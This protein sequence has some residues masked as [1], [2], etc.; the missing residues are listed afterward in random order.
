MKRFAHKG[1]T[2]SKFDCQST[3]SYL[4]EDCLSSAISFLPLHDVLIFASTSNTAMISTLSDLRRRRENMK[5]N[6]TWKDCP[7]STH[8]RVS[9]IQ[10]FDYADAD[11]E[12]G[13]Y[14]LP[15]VLLRLKCLLK[16]IAIKHPLCEDLR[17]LV[18][19]LEGNDESAGTGL[20]LSHGHGGNITFEQTIS[21]FRRI[22]KA[23]KLHT[24]LLQRT[25]YNRDVGNRTS[26]FNLPLYR[27]VGDVLITYFLLGH[28]AA[29]N[30]EGVCER[31]WIKEMHVAQQ[32]NIRR[33]GD[34]NHVYRLLLCYHSTLLRTLPLLKEQM[35][36]IGIANEDML[37]IMM[38]GNAL[39]EDS[40]SLI[41][42][43]TPFRGISKY[44][45][46]QNLRTHTAGISLSCTVY[47]FGPLGPAFRGRD[48][49]TSRPMSSVRSGIDGIT[50]YIHDESSPSS[51]SLL[52]D[53]RENQFEPS[54]DLVDASYQARKN[55]PINVDPARFHI[56][57]FELPREV[58]LGL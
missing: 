12:E 24:S 4:P 53:L 57:I 30:V 22:L 58:L 40:E 9:Y 51:I 6:L 21:S 55:N 47:D 35:I 2:F 33:I 5:L 41:P 43:P 56:S 11:Q 39:L 52:S 14:F 50:D 54:T 7:T 42:Q 44:A 15:S 28:S 45:V 49:A 36:S 48:I 17:Q 32:M 3:L 13:I 46:M 20:N 38:K 8:Q 31:S 16:S 18:L 37:E 23:H 25:I 19:D 34:G 26:K 10:N 29:G 27:Y 1:E